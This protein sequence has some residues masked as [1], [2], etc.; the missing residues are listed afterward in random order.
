MD[1]FKHSV[2]KL[3]E[4]DLEGHAE[5]DGGVLASF[6]ALCDKQIAARNP[7]LKDDFG[8]DPYKIAGDMPQRKHIH[9]WTY[10]GETCGAIIN[11]LD[12]WNE[13]KV[14]YKYTQSQKENT[15][16]C[17]SCSS[18]DL[19]NVTREIR[20]ADEVTMTFFRCVGC[21]SQWRK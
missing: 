11:V 13:W 21:S 7:L 3:R 6:V 14:S 12:E 15:E 19:V 4:C 1:H 10:D 20:A 17:P 5:V 18:N 2:E 16:K 9:A 8:D